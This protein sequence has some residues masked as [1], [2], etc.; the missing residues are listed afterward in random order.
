MTPDLEARLREMVEKVYC[1]IFGFRIEDY[2][3]VHDGDKERDTQFIHAALREVAALAAQEQ[4]EQDEVIM[5]EFVGW[6][7]ADRP[8]LHQTVMWELVESLER[9]LA[10]RATAPEK[11]VPQ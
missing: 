5:R 3:T 1:A 7:S 4:R 11:E 9:F 2:K 8:E 6:L 10:I